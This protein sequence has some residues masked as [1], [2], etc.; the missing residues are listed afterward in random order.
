[1]EA[2]KGTGALTFGEVKTSLLL[3]GGGRGANGECEA[4]F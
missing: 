4:I 2:L 1:M 3:V